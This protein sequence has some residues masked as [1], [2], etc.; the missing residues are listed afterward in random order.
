ML[1]LTVRFL[2]RK[3]KLVQTYHN[4][5]IVMNIS[6]SAVDYFCM[7]LNIDEREN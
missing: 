2:G 4:S 7:E 3:Q 5:Q 1:R 6:E